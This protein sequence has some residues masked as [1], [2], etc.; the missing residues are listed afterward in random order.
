MDWAKK[1]S[2]GSQEAQ[3]SVVGAAR[4]CEVLRRVVSKRGIKHRSL[5]PPAISVYPFSGSKWLGLLRIG[6]I[7]AGGEV[8]GIG[9]VELQEA[10]G[11][12]LVSILSIINSALFESN[13]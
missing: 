11:V 6:V 3:G 13:W 8:G 1:R 2:V 12:G 4:V 7:E 5:A 10:V 9:V